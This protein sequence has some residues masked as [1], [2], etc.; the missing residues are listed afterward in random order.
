MIILQIS[1]RINC[2]IYALGF[3]LFHSLKQIM[4]I[5]VLTKFKDLLERERNNLIIVLS[6]WATELDTHCRLLDIKAFVIH[7]LNVQNF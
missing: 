1:L 7:I 4:A 2:V 5:F 3:S 6:Q